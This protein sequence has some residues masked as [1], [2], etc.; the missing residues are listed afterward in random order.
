MWSVGA[1]FNTF[2][3]LALLPVV[4]LLPLSDKFLTAAKLVLILPSPGQKSPSWWS[5][6]NC[7][8]HLPLLP[9]EPPQPVCSPLATCHGLLCYLPRLLVTTI[10]RASSTGMMSI[11]LCIPSAK[12][13]ACNWRLSQWQRLS[14][15]L[16][17]GHKCLLI[18]IPASLRTMG[19]VY[20]SRVVMFWI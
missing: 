19:S 18:W 12:H 1:F 9:W 2:Q 8:G 13:G 6:S 14:L 11:H 5:T 15:S 20:L 3:H 4:K 7:L 10:W 17:G 16:M